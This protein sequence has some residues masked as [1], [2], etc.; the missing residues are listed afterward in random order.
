MKRSVRS[1]VSGIAAEPLKTRPGPESC[2][3]VP[4]CNPIHRYAL[5]LIPTAGLAHGIGQLT[6]GPFSKE[7]PLLPLV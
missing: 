6:G 3:I 1:L 4:L 5:N 2:R 7:L